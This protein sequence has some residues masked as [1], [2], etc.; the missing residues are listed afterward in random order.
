MFS[1]FKKKEQGVI[2]AP[3]T[4]KLKELSKV[5]DPVFSTGTMGCG[6]A[7]IPENGEICSPVKGK[8]S[9]VFPGGH[10]L[11]ITASDGTEILIHIGIDTV[12]L[13]GNGFEV[14]TSDGAVVKK[15]DLLVKADFKA[16]SSKGCETDVI[17]VLTS[18]EKCAID[19]KLYG[20]KV[21]KSETVIMEYKK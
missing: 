20:K 19:S 11:G 15:G 5:K 3:V 13:K 17:V 9:M 1:L 10:A 2:P 12:K 16:I 4:G 6:F 8:V 7:I 14:F 18:G 21:I